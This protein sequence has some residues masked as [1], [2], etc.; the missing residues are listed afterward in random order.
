MLARLAAV[1]GAHD[2]ISFAEDKVRL[3]GFK[4]D[5]DCPVLQ[6]PLRELTELFPNLNT[7]IVLLVRNEETIIPKK[8]EELQEGDD[9]YLLSD[10]NNIKGF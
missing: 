7:K 6:T 9:I 10:S 3:I 8:T 4:L 5:S 2:L 1:S